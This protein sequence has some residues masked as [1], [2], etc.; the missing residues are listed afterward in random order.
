ME[1][2]HCH[3]AQWEPNGG[4]GGIDP[5]DSTVRAQSRNHKP[6]R[7]KAMILSWGPRWAGGGLGGGLGKSRD[8]GVECGA[9][10]GRGGGGG[11]GAGR[12][13]NIKEIQEA[14]G[15]AEGTSCCWEEWAAYCVHLG[16]L[17]SQLRGDDGCR[18]ALIFMSTDTKSETETDLMSSNNMKEGI[19]SLRICTF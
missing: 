16:L 14:A 1:C 7:S 9:G 13:L 2:Q 4:I 8:D 3:Q 12:N 5:V 19:E 6:L 10:V 17:C 18:Q 15:N 11:G